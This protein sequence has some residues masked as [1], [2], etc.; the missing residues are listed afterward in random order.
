MA[1]SSAAVAGT[2]AT[3]AAFNALRNDVID[4]TTSH[5]HTGSVDHGV[6]IGIV[7]IGGIILWSGSIASIPTHWQACDGTNG[8]PDLR[9]K[10]I[11][12]AG[13]TYAVNATGGASTKNL[14][15]THGA[16]GL[17]TGNSGANHTHLCTE[18]DNYGNSGGAFTVWS[19]MANLPTS[20]GSADHTHAVNGATASGGSATQDILPPYYS[21]CYVM[22]VS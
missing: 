5:D 7:P 4:A 2:A 14:A 1:N 6:Y 15:H 9:D 20:T 3:A 10:F 12:G 13:S 8:T 16:T 22:R 17:S 21:L 18:S 19:R 11:V